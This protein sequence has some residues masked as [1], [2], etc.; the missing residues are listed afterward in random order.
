MDILV[1]N[2]FCELKIKKAVPLISIKKYVIVFEIIQTS[3]KRK[4]YCTR[5]YSNF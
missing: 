1:Q 4:I 3:F 5:A 2:R